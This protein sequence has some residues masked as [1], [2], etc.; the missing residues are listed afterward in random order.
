MGVYNPLKELVLIHSLFSIMST[1]LCCVPARTEMSST[2]SKNDFDVTKDCT[3]QSVF[4]RDCIARLSLN[5]PPS[6]AVDK[7]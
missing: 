5:Y 3:Q 4:P 7:I 2:L 1:K 6:C